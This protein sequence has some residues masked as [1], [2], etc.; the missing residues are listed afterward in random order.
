MEANTISI[1]KKIIEKQKS[2][3]VTGDIIVPDTKPD[4]VNIINT[5]GNAYIYKEDVTSGRVRV[6]GNI[7]TYIIYFSE[8]GETRCMQTTMNFLESID[9]EK[10]SDD[11]K[12]KSNVTIENIETTILNERKISI[13]ANVKISFDVYKKSEISFSNDLNMSDNIECL[14]E[15]VKLKNVIGDGKTKTSIKEDISC[16]NSLEIS[17]IIKTS[18]E[19]KSSENKISYN[20]V[21]AKAEANVKIIFITDNN[22]I[23]C[24]EN[25]IPIMS[26]IDIEKVNENDICNT[27]YKIRNM[28]IKPNSKEM[29]SVNVQIDFDVYCEA[30]ET[31][32]I[33]MIQ[34][35]YGIKEDVT[36]SKKEAD[37]ELDVQEKNETL[38]INE[39]I[40]LEDVSQILDVD[41]QTRIL[42]TT[43]SGDYTNCEGEEILTFFYE[44]DS[45]N[46]L[47]V[48]KVNI[49]FL[50]KVDMDISQCEFNVVEKV[51]TIS[52]ENVECSLEIKIVEKNAKFKKINVIE[53]FETVPCA[54]EDTYKMFIYFVKSGDTIWNISKRFK[55]S[56]DDII[57]INGLENP[58]RINI[59]DRLYIMR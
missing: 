51:F 20:K 57:R 24:I 13:K 21:L 40:I 17:E 44:A 41:C 58:D 6:D 38:K 28:L 22:Q 5:N 37:V 33:E 11:S 34:D 55:V 56:M 43:P 15:N 10:I 42:N 46:G 49:P 32:E 26:F 50:T 2:I 59:G 29:H 25:T 7:D 27:D 36:F 23:S 48:K 30:Y 14:K 53:N 31:K 52:G 54:S 4:I 45:H 3:E 47:S 12:L 18:V 16:D 1:N 19:I 8:N 9:D 35:M 39:R